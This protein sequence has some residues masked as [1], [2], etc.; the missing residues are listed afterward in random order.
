MDDVS[1]QIALR[2]GYLT[3]LQGII[4]R[5]A[6]S[7]STMKAGSVAV[8]TA[9]VACSLGD[10]VQFHAGLFI[11]PGVL[12]MGFHGYFLQQERAFIRLYNQAAGQALSNVLGLRIDTDQLATVREPLVRVLFRP[13]VLGFHIVLVAVSVAVYLFAK[14]DV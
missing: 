6:G 3:I 10:N 13:T 7:A 4:N 12:F 5:L 2:L 9:L 1:N 11:A 8:M 14:G